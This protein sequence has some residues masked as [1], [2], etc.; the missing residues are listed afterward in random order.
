MLV[1]GSCRDKFR[2]ESLP[3]LGY[4]MKMYEGLEA[5]FL[6]FVTSALRRCGWPVSRFDK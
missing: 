5:K 1:L 2:G 3:E 6:E 4:I